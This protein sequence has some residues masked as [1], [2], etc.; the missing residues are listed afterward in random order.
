MLWLT[1]LSFS[2]ITHQHMVCRDRQ[3]NCCIAKMSMSFLLS[4]GHQ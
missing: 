4:C 3:F 1:V 2:N